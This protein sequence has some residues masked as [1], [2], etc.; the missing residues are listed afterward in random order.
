MFIHPFRPPA[1]R[2]STDGALANTRLR[3][4]SFG[5]LTTNDSQA[6][7]NRRPATTVTTRGIRLSRLIASCSSRGRW[8]RAQNPI[9]TKPVNV[10]KLGYE[11][12]SNRNAYGSPSRLATSGSYPEYLV[13][14]N[15]L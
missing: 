4:G 15:R 9:S 10:R 8:D 2:A 3:S 1:S 14:V 7:T 13:N 6:L 11:N 5:S 12:P